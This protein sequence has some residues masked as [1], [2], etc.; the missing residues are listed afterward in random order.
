MRR[1]IW[2]VIFPSEAPLS[3]EVDYADLARRF[4]VTGG[5]IR[6]IALGAAFL[7]ADD[8]GNIDVEHVL[9]A[10]RREFQ[11]MGK[12]VDEVDFGPRQ[13]PA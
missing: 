8:G 5:H 10:A 1:G 7:A 3:G 6:N 13:G 11:K 4:R 12:V 9:Q 2:Q